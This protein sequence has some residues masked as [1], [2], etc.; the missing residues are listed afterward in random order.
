MEQNNGCKRPWYEYYFWLEITAW[1]YYLL[2]AGVLSFASIP[3]LQ[4]RDIPLWYAPQLLFPVSF[5][6]VIFFV[7]PPPQSVKQLQTFRHKLHVVYA[8]VTGVASAAAGVAFMIVQLIYVASD[9]CSIDPNSVCQG[10]IALFVA[11]MMMCGFLVILALAAVATI[12]MSWNPYLRAE[13]N[14]FSPIK[15][16]TSSS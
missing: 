12:V 2:L 6:S 8:F 1:L 5:I 10:R 13:T 14:T 16:T 3:A 4:S 7:G 15:T 11:L 9:T